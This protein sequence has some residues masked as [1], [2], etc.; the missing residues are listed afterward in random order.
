MLIENYPLAWLGHGEGLEGAMLPLIAR[1]AQDDAPLEVIGHFPKRHPLRA[2]LRRDSRATARFTGPQGYI[3]PFHA[4]RRDWGPTWNYCT[5]S[6]SL[7]VEVSDDLTDEAL[8]VL[9][10]HMEASCAAPWRKEEL[11]ARLPQMRERII[12]FRAVVTDV[13]GR[14]KLGQDEQLTDLCH[15]LE[16][17]SDTDLAFWMRRMNRERLKAGC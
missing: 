2:A 14:F 5:L 13:N 10:E 12:G 8:D 15:M 16:T 3:S 7:S 6:L 11:G 9:I 17:I 4:G 1:F